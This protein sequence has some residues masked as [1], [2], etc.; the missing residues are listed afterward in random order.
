LRLGSERHGRIRSPLASVRGRHRADRELCGRRRR[1]HAGP[2]R[3]G[4]QRVARL[5]LA[6]P[7]S[8]GRYAD[9]ARS[10]ADSGLHRIRHGRAERARAHTA[11]IGSV[12]PDFVNFVTLSTLVVVA[13]CRLGSPA[14]RTGT[15]HGTS[16]ESG[17]VRSPRAA[18]FRLQAIGRLARPLI[19][20]SLLLA[21]AI[22]LSQDSLPQEDFDYV[23]WDAYLGG[24]ESSQYT[25]LDQI[26]S[27]NVGQLQVAWEYPI[28]PGQPPQFNPIVAN[29]MMYVLRGDGKIA[30]LDPATGS[31]ILQSETT[32]RIGVRGINYWQSKDGSD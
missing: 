20:L 21:P 30:A 27:D 32:G 28:G 5:V 8:R 23:G 9:S 26:T 3:C 14:G 22:A 11:R 29:G 2:L 18:S 25:A 19:P 17:V 1:A 24:P 12:R 10:G 31:E 16:G 15:A 7:Q 6:E 13:P 4:V